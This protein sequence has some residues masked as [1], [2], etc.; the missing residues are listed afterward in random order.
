MI[1]LDC[2]E[3][4]I[5]IQGMD[6]WKK[7]QVTI[8]SKAKESGIYPLR[9]Q[10][11]AETGGYVL[12]Y[13]A[14]YVMLWQGK[15]VFVECKCTEKELLSL[16]KVSKRQIALMYAVYRNNGIRGLV[17][18]SISSKIYAIPIEC[19]ANRPHTSLYRP[20]PT[21]QILISQVADIIKKEA[22][23]LWQT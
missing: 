15:A 21:E 5:Y 9:L 7:F 14:D 4:Y 13:P 17:I 19:L 1:F 16:N 8:E 6:R 12:P 23:K 22:M 18:A 11:M 20:H 2:Q 10:D 3:G